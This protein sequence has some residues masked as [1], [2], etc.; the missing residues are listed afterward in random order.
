MLG[1][2]GTNKAMNR[3]HARK[4]KPPLDATRLNELALTYVGRFAT[5]RAKLATY[6]HRKIRE[7]GWVGD[8][9]ADVDALVQR[10]SDLGYVDD[11][12][13]ALSKAQSLTGRGYGERRVGQALWVAG[14]SDAD[15]GDARDLASAE[16]LD[17]ALRFARRRRI[18]PFGDGPVDPAKRERSIAAMIRAGHS[19]NLAR[20]IV[21][22][23]PG[24]E[25]DWENF[26]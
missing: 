17:S 20:R 13:Y 10:I 26:I 19:F 2:C 14:I 7:R 11:K 18:G 22:L 6:L 4:T 5:S 12:A 21:E 1:E 15:G 16:A 8:Q 25:P 23:E 24:V 9:S 3:P